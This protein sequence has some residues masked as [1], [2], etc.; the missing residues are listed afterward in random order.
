MNLIRVLSKG[1]PILAAVALAAL[2]ASCGKSSSPTEPTTGGTMTSVG[3][4]AITGSGV[5]PK[6][7]GV[8]FGGKVTITNNDSA[9]HELS[10]N[11]HPFHTD[12]PEINSPVLTTGQSFTATMASKAETCGFHDHLNPTNAA[13]QGTITVSAN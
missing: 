5:S 10:S 11:P 4:I 13:F 6:T 7:L 3:A 9:P 2:V 1:A 8:G 12:C